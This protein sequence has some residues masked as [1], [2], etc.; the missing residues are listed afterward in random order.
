MPGVASKKW[1]ADMPKP[2]RQEPFEIPEAHHEEELRSRGDDSGEQMAEDM[3]ASPVKL[4]G[5][6]WLKWRENKRASRK[7]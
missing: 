2:R 5:N 3:P 1:E 4:G 6:P 7:R